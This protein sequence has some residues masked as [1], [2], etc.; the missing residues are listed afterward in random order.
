MKNFKILILSLFVVIFYSCEKGEIVTGSPVDT[1]LPIENIVASISTAETVVV[2]TQDFIVEVTLPQKFD[3]DVIV[4]AEVFVPE[5][6]TR[7]RRSVVFLVGETVKELKVT[8][9]SAGAFILPYAKY[10]VKVFLIGFNTAPNVVPAGF[11]GKRYAI[12]SNILTLNYGSSDILTANGSRLGINLDFEGPD[13]ASGNNLDV[14]IS[15]NGTIINYPAANNPTAPIYGTSIDTDD[16]EKFYMNSRNIPDNTTYVVALYA[17]SLVISPNNLKYRF[18][19]RF[20]DESVKTFFGTLNNIVV[21]SSG[22]AVN[23][24]QI[25]KTTI[26]V[27]GIPTVKYE[28]IQLP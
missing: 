14:V 23:V 5:L 2:A 27:N 6:N 15:R 12:S 4:Q 11:L 22:T 7:I 8:A 24:L 17:T 13:G 9:P 19:L 28:V 20:P 18:T 25:K 21:G 1:G 16:N 3:V 26:D 10:S